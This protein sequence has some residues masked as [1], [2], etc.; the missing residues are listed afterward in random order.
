[1]LLS[2]RLYILRLLLS[3]RLYIL[4]LL[5]SSRLYILR[6]LLTSRLYILRLLLTSRLYILRLLLSS[7]HYILHCFYHRVCIYFAYLN[8]KPSQ[9]FKHAQNPH[10]SRLS[11]L[12]RLSRSH[13]L[14]FYRSA[15]IT[16]SLRLRL[17]STFELSFNTAKPS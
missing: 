8:K 2:S 4:R 6:L 17:T 16:S 3:S 9:Q 14:T 13:V 5:L 1:L 7:R 10:F 15:A 11:R 12:S